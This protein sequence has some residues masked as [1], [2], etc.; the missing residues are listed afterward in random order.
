M[1]SVIIPVYNVSDTIERC[2]QSVAN[3]TIRSTPIECIIVDDCGND[4]SITK[5]QHFIAAQSNSNIS[6]RIVHHKNNRGLSAAR[7]TGTSATSQQSTWIY[8]LDS[9]DEMT[10][11][12]LQTLLEEGLNGEFDMVCGNTITIPNST[13]EKWRDLRRKKRLPR[14]ITSNG[15]AN[16]FFFDVRYV[17]DWIPVNAWNKLIRTSFIKNNHISFCEGLIHEDE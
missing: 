15:K 1:I 2:L 5:V 9:D 3:Q 13:A 17:K 4:D 14:P 10:P 11:D 8:Y 7:N 16:R 12:A 6:Y